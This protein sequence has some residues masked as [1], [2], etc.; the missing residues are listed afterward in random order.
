M[1]PG[2]ALQTAARGG[3]VIAD[4]CSPTLKGGSQDQILVEPLAVK[5]TLRGC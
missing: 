1:T 2:G 4:S 5:L 3:R